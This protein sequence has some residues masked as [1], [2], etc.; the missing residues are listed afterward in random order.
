MKLKAYNYCAKIVREGYVEPA[1]DSMIDACKVICA[2][3]D[4]AENSSIV[5]IDIPTYDEWQPCGYA[6]WIGHGHIHVHQ[7]MC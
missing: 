4:P 3:Y 1:R 2:K 5:N 7:P 6:Q